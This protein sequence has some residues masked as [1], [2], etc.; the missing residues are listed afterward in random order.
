MLSTEKAHPFTYTALV[1]CVCVFTPGVKGREQLT[2]DFPGTWLQNS[3]SIQVFTEG[4]YCRS[5][6][7]LDLVDKIR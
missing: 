4:I 1:V 7:D 3:Q 5:W 2:E 6:F